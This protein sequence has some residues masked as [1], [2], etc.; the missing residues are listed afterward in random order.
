MKERKP[1]MAKG[2]ANLHILAVRKLGGSE[3]RYTLISP[4]EVAF[5]FLGSALRRGL[6]PGSG[7]LLQSVRANRLYL[8]TGKGVYFS[9][10]RSLRD[11]C[12]HLDPE[13]FLTIQR[14]LAINI[15]K[16]QEVDFREK[17]IGMMNADGTLSWFTV[18]RRYIKGL[19]QK[20][21]LPVKMRSKS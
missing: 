6:I 8:R 2:S 20:L 10:H 17:Q 3:Y 18:S 15:R 13:A 14:S 21:L 5:V 4:S 12:G 19:R 11:L 9:S 7:T 1:A 16:A